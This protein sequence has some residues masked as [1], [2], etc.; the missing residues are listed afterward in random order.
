MLEDEIKRI[1]Q[2]YSHLD[3][4]VWAFKKR[5]G[6]ACV[7]G[8]GQCCHTGELKA[9]ILEFLPAAYEL[10]LKEEANTILDQI[11]RKPDNTCV[12]YNPFSQG[13]NCSIYRYRGLICRLFGFSVKTDKHEVR[14]LVTC[15][16][17]KSSMRS[18]PTTQ[19]LETAPK[20]SSYY[21]RL[22]GIDPALSVRYLPVNQAIKEA[23]EKVLLYF[24]FRRKPA[25]YVDL[26]HE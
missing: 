25:T 3:R 11:T 19:M 14:S 24:T 13:G 2:M 21:M 7:K 6:L 15:Q 20:L 4:H 5:S 17:I 26:L 1:N 22:Y 12:F 18:Y 8:C 23:I 16:P 9:T 10:Y